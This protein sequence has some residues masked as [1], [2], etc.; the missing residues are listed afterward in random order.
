MM[1]TK[2]LLDRYFLECRCQVLELAATL[3]RLDRAP[4]AS[5]QA[6][7]GRLSEIRQAIGILAGPSS[8]PNRTE[9]ILMLLADTAT[10]VRP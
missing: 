5:P 2:S 6:S 8:M 7:D 1:N 3:D 9:R 4:D 10:G